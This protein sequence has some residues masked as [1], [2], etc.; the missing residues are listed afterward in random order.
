MLQLPPTYDPD[1]AIW[2]TCRRPGSISKLGLTYEVDDNCSDT[3]L[4]TAAA[5]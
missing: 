1:K 4:I 2:G 5:I 3:I